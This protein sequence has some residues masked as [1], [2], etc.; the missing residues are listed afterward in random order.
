MKIQETTKKIKIS[1]TNMEQIL[2]IM[3]FAIAS[4]NIIHKIQ[5]FYSYEQKIIKFDVYYFENNTWK[6]KTGN[7]IEKPYTS[8]ASI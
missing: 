7:Q 3:G 2:R 8:T 6:N 1:N 4:F 5:I